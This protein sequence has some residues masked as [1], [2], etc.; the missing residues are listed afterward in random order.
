[1]GRLKEFRS[2]LDA[3]NKQLFELKCLNDD[4]LDE[5]SEE[6]EEY[7]DEILNCIE[8]LQQANTLS[9]ATTAAHNNNGI[10]GSHNLKLPSVSLPEFKNDKSDDL[11]KFLMAFEHIIDRNQLTP[12][13]KF[14]YLRQQLS[15]NPRTIIDSIDARDQKYETAKGL[16]LE[17]FDNKS[18]QKTKSIESLL[19]LKFDEKTDPY[20]FIGELRK[21][22]DNFTSR[23][24]SVEDILQYFVWK[25]LNTRFQNHIIKITK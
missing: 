21:V 20:Q 4:N 15:G 19:E 25:S 23:N 17:A 6:N 24:I 16:L 18:N 2:Q 5:F 9:L 11:T 22:L 8:E 3:Q 12:Y 1:M 13:E 10:N 14:L 7:D